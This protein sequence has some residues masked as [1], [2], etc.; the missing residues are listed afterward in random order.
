MLIYLYLHLN[1]YCHIL[2]GKSEIKNIY[3]KKKKK[4]KIYDH[5]QSWPLIKNFSPEVIKQSMLNPAEH[6]I[7]NAHKYK[8]MM[9]FSFFASSDK[10]RIFF[11]AHKF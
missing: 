1:L 9:K 3:P 6:E 8:N 2:Y 11:S 10:T 4:K 5:S 7:L